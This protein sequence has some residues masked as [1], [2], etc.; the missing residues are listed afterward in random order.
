MSYGQD[1]LLEGEEIKVDSLDK[2]EFRKHVR[3]SFV[4]IYSKVSSSIRLEGERGIV[5]AKIDF[6]KH[7]GLDRH[8]NIYAVSIV[9]RITPHSGLYGSYY[10]LNRKN[11]IVLDEDIPVENDTLKKGLLIDGY[12]NTSVYSF[13]YLHSIL[14]EDN[15]FLGAYINLYVIQLS[16]GVSSEVFDFNKSTTLLAPLPNI[17]ILAAFQLNRSFSIGGNLGVFF[18]NSEYLTGT[19]IDASFALS[20]NPVSWLGISFGYYVFDV[21]AGWPIESIDGFAEYHYGG[22]SLGITFKL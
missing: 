2:S 19:F 16:A 13:G 21:R 4:G 22:P 9:A 7:L 5:S 11:S 8:K 6:E 18:V 10:S 12:F 1:N 15:A 17:G 20:Y 14:K 3:V